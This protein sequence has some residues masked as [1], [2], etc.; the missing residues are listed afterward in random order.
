MIARTA[1]TTGATPVLISATSITKGAICGVTAATR[2]TIRKASVRTVETSTAT[3]RIAKLTRTQVRGGE[4]SS[5]PF[6]LRGVH[7]GPHTTMQAAL[8]C[9]VGQARQGRHA[10]GKRTCKSPRVLSLNVFADPIEIGG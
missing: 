9:P 4:N 8:G 10:R 5:L 3:A 7:P 2:I 1:I 6:Y